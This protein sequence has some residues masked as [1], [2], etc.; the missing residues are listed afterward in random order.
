MLTVKDVAARDDDDGDEDDKYDAFARVTAFRRRITYKMSKANN[1]P[2]PPAIPPLDIRSVNPTV[3]PLVVSVKP[4]DI[5]E[6]SLFTLL[7]NDGDDDD[8]RTCCV[9][10]AATV[11]AALILTLALFPPD[12]V[13]G[14]I[15]KLL[16]LLL[17]IKPVGDRLGVLELLGDMEGEAP[18][19]NDD[20]GDAVTV[21]LV[22][23][24]LESE[25][26]AVLLDVKV[27]E[28]DGVVVGVGEEEDVIDIV[29]LSV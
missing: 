16:L 2:R 29:T 9:S 5:P 1:K 21:I 11:V 24:V 14:V 26:V 22:D 25:A 19:D 10:E 17:T 7:L 20:V 18:F 6:V 8:N 13:V 28:A 15:V 23:A 3:L 4:A 12:A 27:P